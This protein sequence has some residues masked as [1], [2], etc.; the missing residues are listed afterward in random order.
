MRPLL[1]SA[2]GL[3]LTSSVV[4]APGA[5]ARTT[6]P[7]EPVVPVTSA[8]VTI[9]GD[10]FG[11][12]IGLSQYG[13]QAQAQANR[14]AATI[15]AFYY[16]G[17]ARSS[18]TAMVRVLISR[19]SDHNTI[20]RAAPGLRLTNLATGRAYLLPTA[21]NANAWRL[22]VVAGKT[23]VS[24]RR[25]GVWHTYLPG[26]KVLS[27]VGEFRTKS[28]L[29]TLVYGGADHVYRGGMRLAGGHTVNALNLENYLKGVIPSEMP[30]LWQ[31]EALRA[32][33]VAARTYAAF[34]RAANLTSR[35]QICDTSA[36]Q[37]YNGY[38]AEQPST[39]AAVAAT[40]GWIQTSGGAPAFTQF[41]ASNGG[42]SVAGGHPYLIAQADP[43][44]MAYRHWTKTVTPAALQAAYPG[45]GAPVSLQILARDGNGEWGGRVTSI[46]IRF[47]TGQPQTISGS[48]FRSQFGLRSSLFT[49]TP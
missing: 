41:S 42:Y 11:H 35:Y 46:R 34:E 39:N 4:L 25:A 21:N 30:A 13:A 29:I 48:L 28:G 31:S 7:P 40:S 32:Q 47:T 43:W 3:L 26:G 22:D 27:G 18:L 9:T 23:R 2:V 20:V 36:C 33:A 15:I 5:Q 1:A 8:G 17:T 37:V 44:D 12:G 45:Q 10:G 14:T 6:A 16:P 24:W 19:D 38:S 49:L